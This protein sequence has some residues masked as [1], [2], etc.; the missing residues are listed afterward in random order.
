MKI[1]DR[2]QKRKMFLLRQT[3]FKNVNNDQK[4]WVENPI[5]EIFLRR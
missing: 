2:F 1:F 4:D 3:N 5:P